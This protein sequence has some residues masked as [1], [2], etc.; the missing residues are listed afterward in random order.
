MKAPIKFGLVLL[1]SMTLTGVYAQQG[2]GRNNQDP[3]ASTKQQIEQLKGF[4]KVNK[5]EEAKLSEIFLKSNKQR[6]TQMQAARE[7]GD[8]SAVREKMQKMNKKRDEEIKKVLGDKRMEK[9]LA[10]MAKVRQQ[11]G[12]QRRS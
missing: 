8:R 6:Q 7:S 3:E 4:V 9:Y 11:R 10:E 12:G 1:L 5:K 2:Q